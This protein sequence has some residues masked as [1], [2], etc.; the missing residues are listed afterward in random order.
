MLL[1]TTQQVR[2]PLRQIDCPGSTHGRAPP[3]DHR[4]QKHR[5]RRHGA[6][7]EEEEKDVDEVLHEEE[8]DCEHQGPEE[9][10]VVAAVILH[11]EDLLVELCRFLRPAQILHTVPRA[12]HDEA[13]GKEGHEDLAKD[14]SIDALV[15]PARG[16]KGL[17]ALECQQHLPTCRFRNCHR[18]EAWSLMRE[19]LGP[20]RQRHLHRGTFLR[21]DDNEELGPCSLRV[22]R[23]LRESAIPLQDE[24]R[25]SGAPVLSVAA[26]GVACRV[27]NRHA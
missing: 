26:I 20:W 14:V 2:D 12:Q 15:V 8:E 7:G 27:H 3:A 16:Y 9:H 18:Q 23:L 1:G 5:R 24:E 10:K 13:H 6:G 4:L 21:C 22:P 11:C 19:H 17:A 25:A